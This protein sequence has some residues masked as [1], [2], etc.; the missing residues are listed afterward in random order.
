MS[1]F[2]APFAATADHALSRAHSRVAEQDLPPYVMREDLVPEIRA[3]LS[4]LLPEQHAHVWAAVRL[5]REARG[6]GVRLGYARALALVEAPA[7]RTLGRAVILRGE[8][9]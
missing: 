3:A 8:R 7:Q 2:L 4:T 9:D 6:R 5:V 1:H